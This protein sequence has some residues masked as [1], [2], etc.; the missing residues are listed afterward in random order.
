MNATRTIITFRK[1][2]EPYGWLGN[3][4]AYPIRHEGKCYRT[5][6][7]LFQALRFDD[8]AI[9]NEI[10]IQSSPMIAKHKA[11]KYSDSFVVQ[12]KSPQD[13]SNMKYVLSQKAAQNPD[14]KR[15]LLATGDSE[16]IEDT[17]AR[18]D[19]F[20]GAANVKGQWV[21]ENQLG[22]LWMEIREELRS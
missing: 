13:L 15:W 4:S 6:E 21:G 3:M 5:A 8:Q 19:R 7:A 1:T 18:R 11:K 10:W 12:P 2:S 14:I 20:W 16:I 22:K 17:T 9:R